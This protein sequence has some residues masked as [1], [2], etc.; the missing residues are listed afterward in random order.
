M[1]RRLLLR[2]GPVAGRWSSTPTCGRQRHR[3]RRAVHLL[4][5]LLHR[6]G[7]CLQQA[8]RRSAAWRSTTTSTPATCS[9]TRAPRSGFLRKKNKDP[10]LGEPPRVA[11]RSER[12]RR[13]SSRTD[14]DKV[15]EMWDDAPVAT[16]T[17]SRTPRTTTSARD[18]DERSPWLLF[19]NVEELRERVTYKFYRFYFKIP[20]EV[21][22]R[23]PRRGA[24]LHRRRT[25]R[26]HLRPRSIR[27]CTTIAI[28]CSKDMT[29]LAKEGSKQ[30]WSIT[31]LR[32]THAIALQRRG[33]ASLAALLQAHR[34]INLL[35]AVIN[36]WHRAQGRRARIS[37]RKLRSR[38]RQA[39]AQEGGQGTR[40]RQ[41]VARGAGSPRV[42]DAIS[43]WRC[44]STRKSRRSSIAVTTSTWSCKTSGSNCKSKTPDPGGHRFPELAGIGAIAISIISRNCCNIFRDAHKAMKSMLKHGRRT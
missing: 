7:A 35:N 40:E 33:Q 36:G 39:A 2:L 23:R 3:Q 11:G 31:E 38:R 24:G 12:R 28:S 5:S 29:D 30:P 43:R 4:A 37:R 15:A 16:T 18:F 14:D 9:I 32:E 42:H 8:H 6:P 10:R 20:K 25:R 17:A 22:S 26:P 44:T 41:Q 1:V 19:D 13:K 27:G 34:R 21:D